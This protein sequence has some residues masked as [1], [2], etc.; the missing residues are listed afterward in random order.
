MIKNVLTIAGS[1]PSG[2]AGIQADLKT[3]SALGCYGMA[4]MTALTA[5]NTQGVSSVH[6]VPHDFV[7]QQIKA[8]FDDIRV[9]AVKIGMAGSVETI[10]I[11]AQLLQHYKPQHIVLDPVMV[12][13]SGDKLI[14]DASVEAMKQYLIPIAT[15]ITPN[16]PEADVLGSRDASALL[17]LGS[18]A[19][20]LKGGHE[21]GAESIDIFVSASSAFQ[22]AAPRVVTKNNHGTGCTL[23]SAIA[24]YLAKGA[25][26]ED[27]V[28]NA[29]FYVTDA[30]KAADRLDVG[31]GHGPVHHFF[32]I[33]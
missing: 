19:V 28:R 31:K 23:A 33:Y 10:R 27:A 12:A 14:S 4:V 13:Q 17:K 30:L 21:D 7:A 2:G 32:E 1:D 11:I 20:F 26:I 9:D 18:K 16:L 22:I 24:A 3:F 15:I 29:K 8:I 6:E 25:S 5:Q